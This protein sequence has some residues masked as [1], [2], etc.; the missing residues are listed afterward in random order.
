M[1]ALNILVL[2]LVGVLATVLIQKYVQLDE[3]IPKIIIAILWVVIVV[4]MIRMTG[5]LI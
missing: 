4:S 2:L 5:V 1:V 3:P